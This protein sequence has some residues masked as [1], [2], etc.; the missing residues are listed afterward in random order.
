MNTH[1]P[2]LISRGLIGA[3]LLVLAGC[4]GGTGVGPLSRDP[5]I[6]DR[7][8]DTIQKRDDNDHARRTQAENNRMEVARERLKLERDM[9][10]ANAA[11]QRDT[12]TM[13]EETNRQGTRL[14]TQAV[15]GFAQLAAILAALCWALKA[16]LGHRADE[17]VFR[18]QSEQKLAAIR[19]VLA[20]LPELPPDIQRAVLLNITDNALT[21]QR[22]DKGTGPD[23]GAK[24]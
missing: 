4:G 18:S 2:N 9:A 3:L 5:S 16:G 11:L 19:G 24:A 6:A 15:S 17:L 22:K 14:R 1:H 10:E 7:Q 8:L 21:D 23:G 20:Q 12:A 13:R